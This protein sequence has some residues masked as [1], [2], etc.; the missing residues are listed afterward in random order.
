MEL[1]WSWGKSTGRMVEQVLYQ[2]VMVK[3][4]L[5]QTLKLSVYRLI[6]IPTLT[7]GHERMRPQIQTDELPWHCILTEHLGEMHGDD[8]DLGVEY[9]KKKWYILYL[10]Y[11]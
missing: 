8:R 2:S 6:Y 10:I 7:Y 11:N 9:L 1:L 3:R 5:N 4:E